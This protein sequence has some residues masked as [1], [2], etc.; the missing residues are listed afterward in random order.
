MAGLILASASPRRAEL[1]AQVGLDFAVRVREIDETPQVNE[2]PGDY[3]ARLALQKSAAVAWDHPGDWVLAA[4][5]CV[6]CAGQIFGKPVD[7]AD[8]MAMWARL[9]GRWHTVYT[10]VAVRHGHRHWH[11]VVGTE[12]EFLPLNLAQMRAYWQSGEPQGKAGGYAIQGRAAG[13]IPQIR[14]S[15]SNVVGLP[16]AQT[17]QLLQQAGFEKFLNH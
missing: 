14:G 12:V 13:F 5:T 3:V 9:S 16:L 2:A 10:G 8:A 1:L 11:T 17:V 7:E 4:D 6:T 15:Y